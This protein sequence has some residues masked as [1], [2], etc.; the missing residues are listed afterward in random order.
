MSFS[1]VIIMVRPPK[2]TFFCQVFR[3]DFE[4]GHFKMS[5]FEISIEESVKKK[6]I[7]IYG[8]FNYTQKKMA[9]KETHTQAGSVQSLINSLNSEKGMAGNSTCDSQKYLQ[10]AH[11]KEQSSTYHSFFSFFRTS[12]GINPNELFGRT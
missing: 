12:I 7:G 5:I 10:K 11:V 2:K 4:I 8:N 6:I 3:E 1:I 9:G